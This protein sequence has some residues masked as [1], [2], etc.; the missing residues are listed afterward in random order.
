MNLR[1]IRTN[2]A[3]AVVMLFYGLVSAVCAGTF[4]VS[5]AAFLIMVGG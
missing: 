5:C 4:M 2:V 3:N 1:Q